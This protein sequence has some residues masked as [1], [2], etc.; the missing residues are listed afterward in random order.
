[1][2]AGMVVLLA[3]CGHAAPAPATG[4]SPPAETATLAGPVEGVCA[5]YGYEMLIQESH[6]TDDGPDLVT[7]VDAAQSAA[8][9]DEA[10]ANAAEGAGRS[11]DAA[12]SF[13][14][15]AKRF[16]AV[17]DG[18][19]MIGTAIY[20]AHVCYDDAIWAFANAGRL[21]AE[22]KA[23]LQQAAAADPRNADYI[24]KQLATDWS[25]CAK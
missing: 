19:P 3:A 10:A 14:A 13:L 6:W 7:A 17:P 24:D 12:L 25:E 23:A 21:A 20:D 9:A 1:M 15:C 4:P 5:R 16:V 22:G 18:D 8:R 2:R 11:R